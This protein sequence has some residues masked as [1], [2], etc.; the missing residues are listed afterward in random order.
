MER[1]LAP[2]L[3]QRFFITG[4]KDDELGERVV[5][6]LE[7]KEKDI[8]FDLKE[9]KEFEKPKAIYYVDSFEETHTKKVDK[10]ST[11]ERLNREVK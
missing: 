2:Q 9:L 10:R 5:L 7:G 1:K 8:T 11:I 6:I 3:T 4:E